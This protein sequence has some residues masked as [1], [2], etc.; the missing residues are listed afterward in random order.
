MSKFDSNK[1]LQVSWFKQYLVRLI[2]TLKFSFE[3]TQ[4]LPVKETLNTLT[5]YYKSKS[6]RFRTL[7]PSK[8]FSF[9]LNAMC[10]C[11]LTSNLSATVVMNINAKQNKE[12]LISSRP[13][14]T[15]IHCFI[16]SLDRNPASDLN[17]FHKDLRLLLLLK[18]KNLIWLYLRCV[19]TQLY[20]AARSRRLC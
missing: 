5:R 17:L 4:A 1:I 18:K 12:H 15:I 9:I 14:L 19:H 6:V 20:F 11:L 7:L 3:Y 16:R 2:V 8:H 10:S 13:H